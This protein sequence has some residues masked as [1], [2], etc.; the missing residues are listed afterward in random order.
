MAKYLSA[1]WI[2]AA[3]EALSSSEALANATRGQR[4]TIQQN[5]EGGPDGE[6]V[7]HVAVDDGTVSFNAG[8]APAPDVTIR[9]DYETSAAMQSG[10]LNQMS[11]FMTGRIKPEG[12][13]MKIMGL[14]GAQGAIDAAL[15]SVETEF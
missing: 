13:M 12:N 11:A 14:Q 9:T 1:E 10:E 4:A 8:P 15:K 5:I 6:I 3:N 7:V 2:A